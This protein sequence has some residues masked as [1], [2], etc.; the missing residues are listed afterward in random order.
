MIGV[1]LMY[2]RYS[3]SQWKLERKLDRAFEEGIKALPT[4]VQE[5]FRQDRIDERRHRELVEA[6]RSV[7]VNIKRSIF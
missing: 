7:K 4:E 6:I 3:E 2:M 1:A 5:K